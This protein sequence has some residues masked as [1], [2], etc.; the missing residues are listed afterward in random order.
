LIKK[1]AILF[2]LDGT[3]VNSA[4]TVLEIINLVR[5]QN[6]Q[7]KL[8]LNP[9][10]EEIIS[11]GGREMI[12]N[13]VSKDNIDKNLNTF[14]ELYED[15]D[16]THERMFDG[17][18]EMLSSLSLQYSLAV[19][20]NK[21]KMLVDKTMN[22]HQIK[23]FFDC[24]VCRED[25]KKKKPDPEGFNFVLKTLNLIKN[26]VIYVGDSLV[27]LELAKSTQVEFFL[28]NRLKI[29]QLKNNL[30]YFQEFDSFEDLT[31]TLGL[32]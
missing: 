19:L 6:N 7:T 22:H 23:S 32:R 31:N 28:Y 13:L 3:L 2:D 18:N 25:V 16:L 29:N 10:I 21:P 17:V 5:S 8:Q 14:R 27:D 30:F 12:V 24:I 26:D 15:Y 11:L 4:P 20:T 9:S 1:K